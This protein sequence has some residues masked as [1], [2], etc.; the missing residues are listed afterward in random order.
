MINDCDL[1]REAIPTQWLNEV[2]VRDVLLQRMPLTALVR[3]LGKMTAVGLVKPLSVAASLVIRKLGDEA[4]L[5]RARSHPLAANAF[6]SWPSLELW[7]CPRKGLSDHA[8]R[9][10]ISFHYDNG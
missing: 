7:W 1:P 4:L 3:N 10:I 5:K 6:G 8:R 9:V 2:E